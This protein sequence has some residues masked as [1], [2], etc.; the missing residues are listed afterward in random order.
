M[1]RI[2]ILMGIALFVCFSCSKKDKHPT[3]EEWLEVYLTQKIK[4]TTEL[5]KQRVAVIVVIDPKEKTIVT[6]LTSSNG[7][8][9]ISETAKREYVEQVEVIINSILEDC[10]LAKIYKLV[11]QYI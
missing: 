3:R 7:Q 1:K 4:N 5:W 10:D 2:F 6:S 8:D 9:E 11:V